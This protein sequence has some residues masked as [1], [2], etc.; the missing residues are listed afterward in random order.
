MAPS[1][2]NALFNRTHRGI[3]PENAS[4]EVKTPDLGGTIPP[5]VDVGSGPPIVFLHGMELD[6][7]LFRPQINHFRKRYRVIAYNLRARSE[8]GE[9][10]YSLYDLVEDLFELLDKLKIGKCVLVGM[11]MGGLL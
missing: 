1:C 11:S 4:P 9:E 10:P 5:F 8:K 7:R 2:F 3:E 6:W